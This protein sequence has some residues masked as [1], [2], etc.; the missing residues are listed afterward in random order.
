MDKVILSVAWYTQ[1]E[2][3]SMFFL[4]CNF[5]AENLQCNFRKV[6]VFSTRRRQG[7]GKTVSKA[8]RARFLSQGERRAKPVSE[9]DFLAGEIQRVFKTPCLSLLLKKI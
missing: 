6:Y 4:A 5:L 7:V 3:M 2:K 9:R 8:E 1:K